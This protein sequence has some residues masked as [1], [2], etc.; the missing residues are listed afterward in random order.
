VMGA[1]CLLLIAASIPNT[2]LIIPLLNLTILK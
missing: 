1:A 2:F